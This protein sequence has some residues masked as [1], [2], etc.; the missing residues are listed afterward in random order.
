MIAQSHV[1]L[2]VP[3]LAEL[4]RQRGRAKALGAVLLHDRRDARSAFS[5]HKEHVSG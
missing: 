5:S 4:R 1:D 2:A 3:D